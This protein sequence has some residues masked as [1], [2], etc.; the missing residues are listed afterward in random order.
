MRL[1]RKLENYMYKTKSRDSIINYFKNNKQDSFSSIDLINYF[2]GKIDKATIYRNLKTLES[3]L[4]IHKVYNEKTNLYEYQLSDDCDNHFH[5]KCI[6][7]GKTIH[8]KC[9]EASEFINHISIEHSFI[10]K[11]SMTTIYG[12]CEGCKNA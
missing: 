1:N 12:M 2:K 6:K 5:L 11:E 7:C 3:E 8:L 4:I 10:V 9:V